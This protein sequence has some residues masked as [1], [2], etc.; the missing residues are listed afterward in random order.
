MELDEELVEH[1]RDP[2]NYGELKDADAIGIGE[3]PQ[4][5]EK[6][7]IYLKVKE[8]NGEKIIEDIKFQAIAC[9]TTVVA[10]SVITNE[11]KGISFEKAEELIAV[12]LGMLEGVPEDQAACTEMVVLALEAA[13]DTYQKKKEDPSIPALIYKISGNCV[14]DAEKNPL[15]NHS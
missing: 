7:I 1:M 11:A 13:M 15:E 4:N 12:T 3:N 6:V 9:V 5:G 14:S 2:K 8:E 10:G